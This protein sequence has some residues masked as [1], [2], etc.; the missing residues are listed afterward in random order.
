MVRKRHCTAFTSLDERYEC[1]KYTCSREDG[2]QSAVMSLASAAGLGSTPPIPVTPY[3]TA[4]AAPHSI[5]CLLQV[6]IE[7][8]RG[9]GPPAAYKIS[10]A[11]DNDEKAVSI[12]GHGERRDGS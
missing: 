12:S 1:R 5:V 7:V 6:V 11:D 4:P 3:T 8:V 2:A 9:A 10:T